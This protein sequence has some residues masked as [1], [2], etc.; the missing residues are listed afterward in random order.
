ME[1][2]PRPSGAPGW[3]VR[4][5]TP[6]HLPSANPQ[7]WGSLWSGPQEPPGRGAPQQTKRR[8]LLT[9]FP[10][11]PPL[12]DSDKGW[13]TRPPLAGSAIVM[14]A[15]APPRAAGSALAPAP[16]TSSPLPLTDV[17]SRKAGLFS[18]RLAAQRCVRAE[19]ERGCGV[20]EAPAALETENPLNLLPKT[21]PRVGASPDIQQ[22]SGS[23]RSC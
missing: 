3:G 13:T 15:S 16:G 22:Q 12:F 11:S 23:W 21:P 1:A 4:A 7:R 19:R 20:E 10:P 14:P 17:R 2:A 8:G 18:G 5:L 9:P 6:P